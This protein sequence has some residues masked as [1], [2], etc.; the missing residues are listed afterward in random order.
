[1]MSP[2]KTLTDAEQRQCQRIWKRFWS[3]T[4]APEE[5]RKQVLKEYLYWWALLHWD[6][7][8][9]HVQADLDYCHAEGIST[10][11][12]HWH[13]LLATKLERRVRK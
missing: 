9:P 6:K 8:V 7:L 10:T 13:R 3:A 12:D 5:T 2:T 11:G 4:K 1:M